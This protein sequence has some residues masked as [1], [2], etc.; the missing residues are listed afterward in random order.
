MRL[1]PPPPTFLPFLSL[2]LFL[3]I[4]PL[5]S[6]STRWTANRNV[7]SSSTVLRQHSPSSLPNAS[8]SL[9]N[10]FPSSVVSGHQPTSLP[11][12]ITCRC[13]LQQREHQ[14]QRAYRRKEKKKKKTAETEKH[15]PLETVYV[16]TV[17][18]RLIPG[19]IWKPTN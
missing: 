3:L 4:L 1:L 12:S 5:H 11:D 8:P 14:W 18:S 17:S 6:P 15:S 13:Q 9:Q 10:I 19:K 16:C 7:V 2:H